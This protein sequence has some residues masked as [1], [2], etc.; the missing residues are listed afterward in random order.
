MA[1]SSSS[2]LSVSRSRIGRID[3]CFAPQSKQPK[4]QKDSEKELEDSEE[5]QLLSDQSSPES[6][7]VIQ[8][9]LKRPG[10]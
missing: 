5:D 3:V 1:K 10:K 9:L 8:S 4:P 7:V 6:D 2:S